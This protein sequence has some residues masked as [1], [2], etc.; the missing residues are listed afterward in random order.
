MQGL[1]GKIALVTGAGGVIG[2]AI[3]LRL[4]RE[5]AIVGALDLDGEAAEATALAITSAGGRAHALQADITDDRAIARA[6]GELGDAAGPVD[7]LVNCAGWDRLA[8]F[9]DTDPALWDRLIAINL[10]GPIALHHAVLPGMI[11]RKR[12][13]IVNISSDAGRVGSSGES[14]YAACKGGIIALTKSIAREVAGAGISVNVVCPGPTDTPI[15]RSFLDE[16][17]Y[18]KKLFDALQRSIPMRRLGTGED[19]AGIVAFLASDE[20]SFITGQVI[21][22]S[23]GLT[24]NG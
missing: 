8:R 21:S 1:S 2:R 11:E 14:V 20:A 3:A 12:G 9:V 7:V 13:A 19:I 5:Q 22:V 4:A 24:M 18:G 23:G 10:R 6:I 15:L 16:G 17:D